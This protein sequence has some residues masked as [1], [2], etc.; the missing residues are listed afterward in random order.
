MRKD[1]EAGIGPEGVIQ[2]ISEVRDPEKDV[3]DYQFLEEIRKV[4]PAS[5]KK[6]NDGLANWIADL[7]VFRINGKMVIDEGLI[8]GADKILAEQHGALSRNRISNIAYDSD[9]RPGEKISLADNDVDGHGRLLNM[10]NEFY[11][12]TGRGQ[13]LENLYKDNDLL[14]DC[15]NMAGGNVFGIDPAT[16]LKVAVDKLDEYLSEEETSDYTVIPVHEEDNSVSTQNP[17]PNQGGDNDMTNAELDHAKRTLEGAVER[18]QE[19]TEDIYDAADTLVGYA[20]DVE[21]LE[22]ER[23]AIEDDY[24]ETLRSFQSYVDQQ[25][26][27]LDEAEGYVQ[28]VIS[29]LDNIDLHGEPSDVGLQDTLRNPGF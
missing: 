1:I 29:V 23:D 25:H 11:R 6:G 20:S 9:N 28:D 18:N 26:D 10:V 13:E 5:S 14:L 22:D 15:D 17:E 4:H 21:D 16:G 27:H 3:S 12:A 8:D 19:I 2:A 7:A 24:L